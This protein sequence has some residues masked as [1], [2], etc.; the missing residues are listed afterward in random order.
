MDWNPLDGWWVGGGAKE[1][2][3]GDFRWINDYVDHVVND[4]LSQTGSRPPLPGRLPVELF[5]THHYVIV[6]F[7]V[8]D[9]MKA[10]RLRVFAAPTKLRLEGLPQERKQVVELPSAVR[11]ESARALYKNGVLQVKLAKRGRRERFEE[12]FIRFE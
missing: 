2:K 1:S 8:P 12:I 11:P 3:Q 5:Q 4:A 9:G 7:R 10:R 6:R